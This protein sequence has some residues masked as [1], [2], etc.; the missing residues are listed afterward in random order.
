MMG[1]L[2]AIGRA[3]VPAVGK[4]TTTI[5]KNAVKKNNSTKQVMQPIVQQPYD[6]SSI[7]DGFNQQNALQMQQMQDYYNKQMLDFQNQ[8]KA[9]EL[10]T[11]Q[12]TNYTNQNKQN[13]TGSV[14]GTIG[15]VGYQP[16]QVK[17]G[18][19]IKINNGQPG[20]ISRYLASDMWK[21]K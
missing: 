17:Q 15:G 4:V 12:T 9:K 6:M 3:I 19:H 7:L 13:I 2:G 18:A 16:Q 20:A 10:Q 5:A 11:T 8:L 14:Q 21:N 1:I